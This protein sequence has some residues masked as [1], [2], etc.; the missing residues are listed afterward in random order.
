MKLTTSGENFCSK[1][2][3]ALAS[4]VVDG[5]SAESAFC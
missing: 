1:R 4:S 2:A 5:S 3:C